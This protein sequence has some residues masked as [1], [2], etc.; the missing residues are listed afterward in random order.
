MKSNTEGRR[1][2]HQQPSSSS[3]PLLSIFSR[4][5]SRMPNLFNI[6]R[7]CL[8]V[9]ILIWTV[10]CFAIAVHFQGLL[11]ASDLTRFVPFAIFVCVSGLLVILALIGFTFRRNMN[12]ISTRMELA[13]LAFAGT[14]W[15]ALGAFLVTSDS[16]DADVECYSS[17]SSTTPLDSSAAF[18]TDTYHAQYRVLEA[19]SLFNAILFWGFFIILLCLALRQH[20]LG[21]YQVWHVPVTS[22]P[23]F[24]HYSKSSAKLPQPVTSRSRSRGRAYNEKDVGGLHHSTSKRSHYVPPSSRKNDSRTA[25]QED[26]FSTVDRIRA[27]WKAK[28]S[29]SR[30]GRPDRAHTTDSYEKQFPTHIHDKFARGASPRR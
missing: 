22:Y 5:S 4:S 19:F 16:N 30:P 29:S 21:E 6:I 11:A 13:C 9:A 25:P 24:N 3:Y 20:T 27:T 26:R 2:K 1:S 15:I 10:V 12:P 18:N 28:H 14:L 23:F 17:A 7:A 8:Y